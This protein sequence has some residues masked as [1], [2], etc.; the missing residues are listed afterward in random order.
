MPIGPAYW[1]DLDEN[2]DRLDVRA[3]AARVTAPW[4]IV[5]GEADESVATDDA[6][7]LFEMAGENSELLLVEGADHT[8][9]ARHPYAGATPELKTAAEATLDWFDRHLVATFERPFGSLWTAPGAAA[10]VSLLPG[11]LPRARP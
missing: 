5:H 4:L 10:M 9:G 2:T 8:F 11:L 6:R 1:R 3:A 7:S